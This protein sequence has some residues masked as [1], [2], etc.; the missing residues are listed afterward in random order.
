[1]QIGHSS[2]DLG[3]T[4]LK[5]LPAAVLDHHPINTIFHVGILH[6][7]SLSPLSSPPLPTGWLLDP[8]QRPDFNKLAVQFDSMCLDPLRYL[9]TLVDGQVEDYSALPCNDAAEVDKHVYETPMDEGGYP[10]AFSDVGEYDNPDEVC[11]CLCVCASV[12]VHALCGSI[13]PVLLPYQ[14]SLSRPHPFPSSPL[15]SP[16]PPTPIAG[17]CLP[18]PCAFSESQPRS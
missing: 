16:S 14:P 1:M 12:R 11:V 7:V 13:Q 17:R 10:M 9:S 3:S 8:A 2:D 18:E 15:P 6:F 4:G 5:C